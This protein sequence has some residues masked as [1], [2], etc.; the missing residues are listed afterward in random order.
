MRTLGWM[1]AASLLCKVASA[2]PQVGDTVV[3]GGRSFPFAEVPMLG[4]WDFEERTGFKVGTGREQPPPFDV[5]STANWDGYEATF[6]IR[7]SKLFLRE[8]VG[9]LDGKKRT[10]QEILPGRAFPVVATWFTGRIHLGVGDPRE[11]T[12]EM[13]AVIVFEIERG[14]V[15]SMS[16]KERMK[17]LW[18]WNGLPDPAAEALNRTTPA[19]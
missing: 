11:D 9:S 18:T 5:R 3:F 4:L 14:H 10:N 8:I 15:K 19:P 2:T 16:F 12:G 6:E 17:P 1:L 13:T 7:E